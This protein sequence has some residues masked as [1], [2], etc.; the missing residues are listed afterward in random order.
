[1]RIDRAIKEFSE[2]YDRDAIQ[3][4]DEI[5]RERGLVIHEHT[6]NTF[7]MNECFDTFNKYLNGYANFQVES[8]NKPNTPSLKELKES[9]DKFINTSLFKETTTK[10]SD[11]PEFIAGYINGVNSLCETVDEVKRIMTDGEVDGNAIGIV[12]EFT[13]IFMYRLHESFDPMMET[14]LWASGYNG[15][16]RLAE[17]NKTPTPVFL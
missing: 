10:Y 14:I 2:K 11:L 5:S 3:S 13:D 4:I 15:K 7:N 16:K 8:V 12:N 6:I 9:V 17:G 1:M